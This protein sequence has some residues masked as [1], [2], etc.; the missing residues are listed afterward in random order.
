VISKNGPTF[1]LPNTS[2]VHRIFVGV[3]FGASERFEQVHFL[4]V[5]PAPSTPVVANPLRLPTQHVDLEGFI[6]ISQVF[7]D[8]ARPFGAWFFTENESIIIALHD[9]ATPVTVGNF[10]GYLL[11]GQYDGTY[12][13]RS[14]PNFIAQ[15][16]GYG[17]ASAAATPTQWAEVVK[18]SNIFNE[19]GLSNV[20]G[21]IAMAKVP[22]IR[23]GGSSEWFLNIGV[24][25]PANLDFQ[26]GGFTAF[27]SI[28]GPAGRAT[29][30]AIANLVTG[31]YLIEVARQAPRLVEDIPV[32]NVQVAPATLSANSLLRMDATGLTAPVV[33]TLVSNSDETVLDAAVVGPLL[34][35]AA[36]GPAGSVNLT[37]RAVNLDGNIVE[38]VMPI[39]IDDVLIPGLRLLSLRGTRPTG[40]ILVKGSATDTVG[41]GS[42]RYRINRKR[43]ITGGILRGTS[44]VFSKKIRGIKKGKNAIEF[45]ALDAR[46]NSSGILRQTF[47]LE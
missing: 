33:I 2:K 28:V 7:Q 36:K 26:N 47:T 32:L 20:P 31:D 16:G 9:T 6:D 12:F 35:V 17:P 42:W 29:A 46:R 30:A 44:M 5:L 39:T 41:L 40:T 10:L 23:D 21:T 13:H 22:G 1:S 15:G 38:Y 19:P 37:L 8:P 18:F 24:D 45:E 34:Y 14:I 25:N 4:R 3:E 11:R 27:G 43:W